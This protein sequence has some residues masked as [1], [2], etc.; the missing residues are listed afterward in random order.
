M[1]KKL[2]LTELA[3]IALAGLSLAACPAG[4]GSTGGGLSPED[5]PELPESAGYVS[6]ETEAKALLGALEP[7]FLTLRN[8]LDTLIQ[9]AREGDETNYSWMLVYDQPSEALKINSLGRATLEM[10]L[11]ED[12]ENPENWYNLSGVLVDGSQNE[13]TTIEFTGNKTLGEAAVYQ[14]S[15]AAE[16]MSASY[17][18]TVKAITPENS[19]TGMRITVTVDASGQISQDYGLT[20]SSGGKGGKLI[21][22]AAAGLSLHSDFTFSFSEIAEMGENGPDMSLISPIFSGSLSVYG[23]GNAAVYELPIT[24]QESYEEAL[25]YFSYFDSRSEF[26]PGD[27]PE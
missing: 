14:G 27:Y 20:A 4:G 3:G 24:S 25:G 6:N 8:S 2:T 12:P 21:L 9:G 11:P 17:K 7:G 15:K 22:K 13:N 19:P 10:N 23:D 5:L 26:F 16:K 1:K 18:T